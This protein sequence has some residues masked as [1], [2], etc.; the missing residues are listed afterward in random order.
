MGHYM[1]ASRTTLLIDAEAAFKKLTAAFEKLCDPVQQAASRAE[2]NRRNAPRRKRASPSFGASPKKSWGGG[3]GGGSFSG[4]G[5]GGGGGGAGTA[6]SRREAP[7]WCRE[8]EYV[9]DQKREKEEETPDAGKRKVGVV[10]SMRDLVMRTREGVSKAG[11]RQIS[12]FG[13][14]TDAPMTV[15]YY[16]CSLF[17]QPWVAGTSANIATEQPQSRV[18]FEPSSNKFYPLRHSCKYL[19]IVPVHFFVLG[20]SSLAFKLL[21]RLEFKLGAGPTHN[22]VDINS[23]S[24]FILK[25][26]GYFT[27]SGTQIQRPSYAWACR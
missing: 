25:K 23:Y 6:G 16:C 7:R 21:K 19:Y 26:A 8:G 1:S 18:G 12:C 5:G 4:D 9:P 17:A 22:T 15:Y 24:C 3:G 13:V 11:S 20:R 2:A 27:S 10:Y 14:G